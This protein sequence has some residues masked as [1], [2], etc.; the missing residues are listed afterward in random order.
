MK[1][2]VAKMFFS[3]KTYLVS[4]HGARVERH[5]NG[6]DADSSHLGRTQ[7]T[8]NDETNCAAIVR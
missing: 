1:N 7:E 5:G 8:E 4:N 2:T 3:L 6:Q